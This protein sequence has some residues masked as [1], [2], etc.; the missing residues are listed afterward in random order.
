MVQDTSCE[1]HCHRF[2]FTVAVV[3]CVDQVGHVR[4]RE[5]ELTQVE[6]EH[7]HASVGLLNNV[8]W[9]LVPG[10]Q[11][12]LHFVAPVV[13]SLRYSSQTHCRILLFIFHASMA[14]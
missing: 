4:C 3:T 2:V 13:L 10:R 5:P 11:R 7:T 1:E 12:S 9:T 14:C 8:C 6:I